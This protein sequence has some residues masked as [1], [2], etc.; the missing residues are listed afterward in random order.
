MCV[1]AILV[2]RTETELVQV[3]GQSALHH[4]FQASQGYIVKPWLNIK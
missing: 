1:H 4:K 2:W 3:W